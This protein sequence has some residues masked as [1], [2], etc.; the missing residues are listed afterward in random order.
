MR[1][2]PLSIRRPESSPRRSASGDRSSGRARAC[3]GRS[4]AA[5]WRLLQLA[6]VIWLGACG[7][8]QSAAEKP[9]A[10]QLSAGEKCIQEANLDLTPPIDAPARIDVAHIVV[11]HDQ[12]KGAI[13]AGVTRSRE[14]ACL[15]ARKAR[16]FLLS[17]SD[18]E[19]GYET[20]SDGK[21]AAKGELSNIGQTDVEEPFANVAFSLQLNELSYVVESRHGFHVILRRR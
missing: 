4:L 9:K 21:G 13:S 15:R 3:T 19:A 18:W 10:Q 20:Y 1:L 12:V 11:K 8:G 14:E 16:D 6:S 7:G 2:T 17:S 5:S